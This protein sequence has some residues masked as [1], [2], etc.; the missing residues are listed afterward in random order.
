MKT[1]IIDTII[2]NEVVKVELDFFSEDDLIELSRIYHSWV[3]LSN[4]IESRG[5]RRINIPELL[6]EAIFSYNFNAG[7]FKKSIRGNFNAS[8]DCLKTDPITSRV[9]V[10]ACSV[11]YDLTSF[12]PNSVWDELYFVHFLPDNNYDGEYRIYKID[13]NLIYNHKVNKDQTMRDQQKQGR[14]P[15]FGILKEIIIPN[16]IAPV[17]ET[18]L[19][20]LK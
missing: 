16:N 3:Q 11:E 9:Q 5:G 15:R 7:R 12:G 19:P 6:S 13:N 1:K 20:N 2:E 8:F 10:K 4:M 18:V 17:I 14:R